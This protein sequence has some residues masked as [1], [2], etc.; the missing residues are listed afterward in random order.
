MGGEPLAERATYEQ[1][2]AA[3]AAL[4]DEVYLV[5]GFDHGLIGIAEGWIGQS[6]GFV[7]LYDI[8]RCIEVLAES[9]MTLD[10][11]EDYFAHHVIGA[12]MGPGTPVFAMISRAPILVDLPALR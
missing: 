3:L 7:A 8:P 6:R 1:V 5:D 4:D 2:R 11:A 12:Y 10:E 9:G